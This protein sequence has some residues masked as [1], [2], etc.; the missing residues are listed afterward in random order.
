MT[1][2]K[3]GSGVV[4]RFKLEHDM[5]RRFLRVEIAGFWTADDLLAFQ[6]EAASTLQRAIAAGATPGEGRILVVATHFSIQDKNLTDEISRIIPLYGK[7][8]KRIA[9]VG[10]PSAL[11]R[12]QMKRMTG[13]NAST[14][15][16]EDAAQAWLFEA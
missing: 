5:S 15:D 13:G 4:E 16:C 7:L 10:S 1:G 6:R 8:A 14:F 12:L 2:M 3:N 11:Q 9:I